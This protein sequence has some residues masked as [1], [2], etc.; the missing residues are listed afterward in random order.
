MSRA[1]PSFVAGLL[2]AVVA[3]AA[4]LPA[5]RAQ[6]VYVA[7]SADDGNDS[8]TCRGVF[9]IDTEAECEA[10]SRMLSLGDYAANTTRLSGSNP[11]GCYY[12]AGTPNRLYWAPNGNPN[13]FL[14]GSGQLSIC[15]EFLLKPPDSP[16][17]QPRFSTP[18]HS[19]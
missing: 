10:G 5:I 17:N 7:R 12:E 16:T 13:F 6:I 15:R 3:A 19:S 2:L 1:A 14:T 18:R 9:G 11:L 4:M 8:G